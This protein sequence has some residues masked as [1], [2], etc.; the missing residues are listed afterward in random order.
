MEKEKITPENRGRRSGEE[1]NK[2]K[3]K[4]KKGKRKTTKTQF[5]KHS[6]QDLLHG[7]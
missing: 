5:D 3:T 1:K 6:I 2:A 4:G 7:L